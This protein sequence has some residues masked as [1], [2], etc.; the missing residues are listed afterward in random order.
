M[1]SARSDL[2]FETNSWVVCVFV[3]LC[4]CVCVCLCVCSSWALTLFFCLSCFQVPWG[5]GSSHVSTR[6]ALE[7]GPRHWIQSTCLSEELQLYTVGLFLSSLLVSYI[8][9]PP[10]VGYQQSTPDTWYR[11][12]KNKVRPKAHCVCACTSM[13]SNSPPQ[14]KVGFATTQLSA[15]KSF[16]WSLSPWYAS[17][18]SS[19]PGAPS[20]TERQIVL[21]L[22]KGYKCMMDER[23]YG[24]HSCPE[25]TEEK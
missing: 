1:Y 12:L 19:H 2:S 8:Y 23:R 16:L 7:L 18:A 14:N 17:D 10:L 22:W 25:E 11:Q 15:G 5:W 3:C 13:Q 9:T 21:G 4:L 20:L 24:K 6:E